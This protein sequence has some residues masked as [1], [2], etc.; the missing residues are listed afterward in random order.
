MKAKAMTTIQMIVTAAAPAAIR[1]AR[2]ISSAHRASASV[3]I[4][5]DAACTTVA[6][7]AARDSASVLLPAGFFADSGSFA[8]ARI[9]SA[10]KA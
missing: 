9:S 7:T 6:A 3:R 4:T 2:P 1:I 8:T 10:I 5:D